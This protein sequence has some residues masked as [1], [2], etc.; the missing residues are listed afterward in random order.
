[1][2]SLNRFGI[3][4]INSLTF[5]DVTLIQVGGNLLY[6]LLPIATRNNYTYLQKYE[7]DFPLAAASEPS[8]TCDSTMKNSPSKL[9]KRDVGL[10]TMRQ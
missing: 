8:G 2:A 7:T 10:A 4:L 9:D 3:G 5:G 1:M 6:Q